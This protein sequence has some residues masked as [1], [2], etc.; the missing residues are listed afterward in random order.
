MVGS[1]ADG[2]VRPRWNSA[3]EMP[4]A[5]ALA[6]ALAMRPDLSLPRANH[7]RGAPRQGSVKLPRP[8]YRS[9]TRSVGRDLQ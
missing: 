7:R 3:L 4:L 6:R 2:Q 8:Q 9:S 5:R 1:G